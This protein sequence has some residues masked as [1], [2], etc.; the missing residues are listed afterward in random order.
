V[1]DIDN[2][3][4]N[5]AFPSVNEA[6]RAGNESLTGTELADLAHRFTQATD[7]LVRAREALTK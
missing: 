3:Y 7:A 2:G 5:M 6:L 4:A 1:A